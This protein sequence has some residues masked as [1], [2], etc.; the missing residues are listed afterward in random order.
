MIRPT[1]AALLLIAP[2]QTAHAGSCAAVA[3]PAVSY[4]TVYP[5]KKVEVAY[6][7]PVVPVVAVSVL[8]PAY[9]ASYVPGAPV[10]VPQAPQAAAKP[11]ALEA[12]LAKLEGI[13]ARIKALESGGEFTVPKESAR[14]P[15]AD[16]F[17]L[18][19]RTSCLKCHGGSAPKGGL[20]L[21]GAWTPEVAKKVVHRTFEVGDMPPKGEPPLAREARSALWQALFTPAKDPAPEPKKLEAKKD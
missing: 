11:D 8:V 1:L 5:A 20:S 14:S 16:P 18:A 17:S 6:A 15:K 12:I 4:P 9:A 21:E 7:V 2:A 19:V 3:Y 13:D 10:A